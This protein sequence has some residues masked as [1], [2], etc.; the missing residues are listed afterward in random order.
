MEEQDI[1]KIAMMYYSRKD[2]QEAILSFCRNRETI[3]RHQDYFGKRPDSLEYHSDI[4]QQVKQGFTSFHCSQELWQDPLKLSTELKPEQLNELRDGWDLL[5]DIDSKYLDYS[6]IAAGLIVDALKFHG[7]KNF[8]I[9]FSGSKGM[10]IIVPWKAFP[11]KINDL[12]TKNMF[13]E[14]P[15]I[16]TQYINE[17][18]KPK[19]T[20][21]ITELTT[22]ESYVKDE[23]ETKKV[24]PDLVLVSS[25]HLFRAPYSLHEKG[26]ASIV[27]DENEIK[28]FNPKL[29]SPF[30]VKVKNFYPDAEENEAKELLVSAL[31][32]YKGKSKEKSRETSNKKYE[33]IKIDKSR[34]VYPPCIDNI[35]KGLQDGRKRAVFILINYFRSLGLDFE[36]IEKKLLDWNLKNKPSLK[37]GYILSQL[38]WAKRQKSILPPNCDKDYYK[39]IGV[40]QADDFCSRIKNPVNY[41]VRKAKIQKII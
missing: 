38:S 21:K 7:I 23:E 41:S 28:D 40:C 20:E 22:K 32:W 14:W 9:K 3:A 39:G 6:K 4:I 31:D 12:Q 25:R 1:K 15:R 10:H 35:M 19:L 17:L 18:I 2:V 24:T 37:E 5:I 30:R 33:E 8:G 13:P 11:K 36:E 27:L 16:I 29:A 34:I 26:F